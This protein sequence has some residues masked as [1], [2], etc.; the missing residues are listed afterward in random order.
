M[1]IYANYDRSGNLTPVAG[2]NFSPERIPSRI[3]LLQILVFNWIMFNYYSASIVS[4]RLSE[5]LDMMED[6]ITVLADSDLRIAAEAVPYLNYFLYVCV[7]LDT[8]RFST[9]GNN[10]GITFQ[11]NYSYM[12]LTETQLGVKLL[13]EEALGSSGGVEEVFAARGGYEAG[14]RRR[15]GVSH[16]SQHGVSLH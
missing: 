16:G 5:P 7:L 11:T 3:A 8:L 1:T 14:E 4:A 15:L 10:A 6:S 2:A 9:Q 12:K 13:Q